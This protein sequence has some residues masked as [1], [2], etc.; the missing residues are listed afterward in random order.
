MPA[1]T[2]YPI[3][4]IIALYSNSSTF[5]FQQY[6][7][8]YKVYNKIQNFFVITKAWKRLF[9]YFLEYSILHFGLWKWK[10]HFKCDFYYLHAYII[11]FFKLMM[12]ESWKERL[13]MWD[14]DEGWHSI[15]FQLCLSG[16][17]T[18]GNSKCIPILPYLSFFFKKLSVNRNLLR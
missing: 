7:S 5:S 4:S 11:I 2:M 10:L 17:Y 8:Y 12:D 13:W 9:I 18:P 6:F 14:W 16:F 3:F 1:L 15:S